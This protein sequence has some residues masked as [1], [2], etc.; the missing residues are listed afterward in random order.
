MRPKVGSSGLGAGEGGLLSFL[1]LHRK[2]PTTVLS[3]NH[4]WAVGLNP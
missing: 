3:A 1:V 2:N 4:A